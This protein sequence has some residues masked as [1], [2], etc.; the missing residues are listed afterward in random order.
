MEPRSRH[1]TLL[2]KVKLLAVE[3]TCRLSKERLT[4]LVQVITLMTCSRK[5]LD[6]NLD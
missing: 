1:V 3:C 5:V 6:Y 2:T 4:K